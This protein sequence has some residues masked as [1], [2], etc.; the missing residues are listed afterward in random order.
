MRRF[1]TLL[2][3]FSCPFAF[4]Q[5]SQVTVV[6]TTV[7]TTGNGAVFNSTNVA[8]IQ[9]SNNQRIS[10]DIA[11]GNSTVFLNVFGDRNNVLSTIPDDAIITGFRVNIEGRSTQN[12]VQ[13]S[14]VQFTLSGILIGANQAPQAADNSDNFPNNTEATL[15][16]GGPTNL[17][18]LSN[19]TGEDVENPDV[20]IALRFINTTNQASLLDLDSISLTVFYNQRPVAVD[21]QFGTNSPD[22]PISGNV[23][24]NDTDPET[25]RTQLTASVE[26]PPD[27]GTLI[28]N[29]DGSFTYTP[30]PG[31]LGGPITFDYRVTDN[32][33]P[34]NFDIATVT[35]VYPERALPVE[36]ISFNARKA[37][38]G[39]LLSWT[40]GTEINVERYEIERSTD[41]ANFITIGTIPATQSS[42][43]S[44]TDLKPVM[45]TAY[46]RVRNVDIDGAY[47][48]TA[49][50]KYTNGHAETVLK[51]FP[52]S[53]KGFVT[54]QHPSVTGRAIVSI[55][56]Q[57]GKLI[58]TLTL[59][60]GSIATPVDLSTYP[61]GT[62][63]LRYLDENGQT[64]TFRIIKQ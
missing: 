10:S 22:N 33:T 4:S 39:V 32:G 63:L 9:T 23:L 37:G 57:E 8:L 64:E 51:A 48:Y 40:V 44:F 43:Y 24:A 5:F 59:P 29:A 46:Y 56:T 36:F 31:F 25:A 12:R 27:E 17:F 21:D 52:T 50:L 16:Y 38:N 28:L 53:T 41:G 61:A 1:F 11:A 15:T 45:G 18:G 58:R 20:G 60:R 13:A 7:T 6:P 2:S 49:V 34:A 62:Y 35:L 3:L 54:L 55:I 42:S 14:V 47:A 30:P 19:L 26:T